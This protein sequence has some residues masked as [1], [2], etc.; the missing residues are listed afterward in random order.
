[1]Q[2]VVE[3]LMTSY[4]VSGTKNAPLAVLIHG[5]ADTQMTF[6]PILPELNKELQVV[7]LDLPGFGGTAP[8]TEA[9][10]LDNFA[11]F[12][13]S[14]LAKVSIQSPYVMMGHSNGGAILIRGLARG[15]LQTEKLILLS[16][17]GIRDRQ[18]GRKAVLKVIAKTGKA[19]TLALPP[20]VR[21]RLR[22]KLYQVAGSD[23]LVAEH[24]QETFKLTVG[25]DVQDDARKLTIPTLIIVGQ[26][27]TDTPTSYA[28]LLN[29]A[30]DGSELKILEAAGHFV[31]QDQPSAVSRTIK[32]FLY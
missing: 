27:D 2:I 15:K 32:D 22:S 26:N 29:D 17:A 9:W 19:A 1:M 25:Q 12:V 4:N 11:N 3:G 18:R 7:T 24:M 13:H 16:S 5:W 23:M 21:Q 6:K 10:G 20:S 28:K 14:F 31:H 30:I 8:P